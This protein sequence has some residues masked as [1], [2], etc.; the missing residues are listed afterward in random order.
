MILCPGH[1]RWICLASSNTIAQKLSCF[2]NILDTYP[3]ICLR[4]IRYERNLDFK[5]Y[6]LWR[7]APF[8]PVG[9]IVF[10]TIAK[11]VKNSWTWLAVRCADQGVNVL[12]YFY[13]LAKLISLMLG[14]S[15]CE[16]RASGLSGLV[17][18]R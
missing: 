7:H 13:F 14:G 3:N 16:V 8:L 15:L 12:F 11:R 18:T 5:M 9:L 2:K 6:T 17:F 10:I 1:V 4:F